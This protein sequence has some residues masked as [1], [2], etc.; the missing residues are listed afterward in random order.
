MTKIQIKHIQR[1]L[2]GLGLYAGLID[3]FS[4]PKTKAGIGKLMP[5][6]SALL[7][8]DENNQDAEE[9][10]DETEQN[11]SPTAYASIWEGAQRKLTD[12]EIPRIANTIGV[13]ED[14]IHAVLDVEARGKGYDKH[15]VIKL[16]EEHVF[17]R[18]LPKHLRQKAVDL[19]LAY[20]K[21]RSNYK[22]NHTRFLKAYEFHP[23]AALLA[24]SWG[25][26]QVMGFNYRIVGYDNVFDMVKDFAESESQQLQA[27]VEFIKSA[28][29]DDELRRHDWAGFARGYN[30]KGYRRNKYDDRLRARYLWWQQQP[31]VHWTPDSA[32][33]T[34]PTIEE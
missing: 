19:G 9:T 21:W 5:M 31:D 23:E 26:G 30:G 16:F 15:G 29:L 22:N 33:A 13:K 4:G 12:Y 17:Y 8:P 3:G 11:Q 14:E 28:G 10:A 6:L 32:A 24:T 20:P 18:S 1:A 2:S 34:E 25:L 7:L 27:M